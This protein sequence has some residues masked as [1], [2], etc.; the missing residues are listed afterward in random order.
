MEKCAL[1]WQPVCFCWCLGRV[2]ERRATLVVW[3][4]L[5]SY[6]KYF[7]PF[8]FSEICASF[9]VVTVVKAIM[10]TVYTMTSVAH[11]YISANYYCSAV[12]ASRWFHA[13]PS[14][15]CF[16]ELRKNMILSCNIADTFFH[17]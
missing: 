3:L 8:V 7:N 6:C 15:R 13:L 11:L 16:D 12:N 14:L 10:N 1:W 9:H 5:Y 4:L 2:G 17:N